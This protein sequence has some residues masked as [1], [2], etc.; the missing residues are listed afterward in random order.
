MLISY[1]DITSRI[2]E[3]PKWYTKEGYP[4]YC[5]FSPKETGV[6]SVFSILVEIQCQSCHRTF[7]VGEGFNRYNIFE[8]LRLNEEKYINVLEDIVKSYH[9]GDPPRHFCTGGGDTMNCDDIR[10]I[11]V[12]EKKNYPLEWLRREDLEKSC[13]F[14]DNE[15]D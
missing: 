1:D 15:Q 4:R 8:L 6:Y 12:W 3:P 13:N 11:E 10:F 9:Y 7:L 2:S 5:G 14:W